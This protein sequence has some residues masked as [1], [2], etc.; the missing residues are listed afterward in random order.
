MSRFLSV[1]PV[2]GCPQLTSGGRCPE[3][4][5]EQ[6]REKEAR[7]G[8]PN[9]RVRGRRWTEIR[10]AKLREN[11]FCEWP[12]CSSLAE[13]IDHITPLSRGGHPTE[14]ENLQSLCHHHHTQKTREER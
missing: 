6:R 8:S 10:R 12:G 1:C 7:Y 2:E 3:H 9:G 14:W 5:L 11:P 4:A 13:E